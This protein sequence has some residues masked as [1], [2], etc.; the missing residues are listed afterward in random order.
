MLFTHFKLQYHNI[1]CPALVRDFRA[2]T[3]LRGAERRNNRLA[4]LLQRVQNLFM[5]RLG[6]GLRKSS[7]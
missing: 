3:L 4:N 5:R 7:F 1:Q 2:P 6:G